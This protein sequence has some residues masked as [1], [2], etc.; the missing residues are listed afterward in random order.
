M[1]FWRVVTAILLSCSTGCGGGG[2]SAG[3]APPPGPTPAPAGKITHVVIVFQENRTPD[4][5]FHG[6]P[7]ADIANSGLN[8]H[9]QSVTLQ[10]VDLTAP[11]DIDHSHDKAFV[12]E[13]NGGQMNGFDN[14]DIDCSTPGCPATAYGYVPQS[15]VQPY[16]T[17]AQA[18]TFAD[19]M[20]QSNAGPS[21]PAHQY[22]LSGTSTNATGSTL[23]AA[24]NPDYANNNNTNCD[25]DP[26]STV[27][28]IDPSGG[29]TTKLQPCFDHETLFDA[30]DAKHISYR[31][32]ATGTSGLWVAPDAISHIKNG[33]DW[34]NV[35]STSAQI[36][37]DIANGQ[38]AAVSWVT[39][40][41]AASDHAKSNDG[42]GPAWVASI[43]NA[44][45]NSAYWQNTAIFITWDD[46]GGWY[47]HVAPPQYNPNELG[48]RVP[49]IVVSAYAR[50]GYVSH[51]QHEFGSILHFTEETFGLASLGYTDARADDLADCFNF[52][53]T[54]LTF[55]TVQS[56]RRAS[57]FTHLPPSNAPVDTD[58]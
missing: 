24:E 36:L 7:N 29:E 56:D 48:F 55:K 31:Y 2:G 44:I 34:A 49:L 3:G 32:Y 12:T 11:Y 41:A 14:V 27:K 9:N 50:P 37:T 15:E 53:Q 35:D 45:G 57:F 42:T 47:D 13:Y 33:A 54:P 8:S 46:W 52:T 10:P 19:R 23:L 26:N 17:L 28:M 22:I 51:V 39:P 25:G 16:F 1:R 21:F 4:N 43:V 40:T 20:F 38:L 5:L 58:F 18:Y 6:L 30:L